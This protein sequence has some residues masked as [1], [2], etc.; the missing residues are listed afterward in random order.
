M[1]PDDEVENDSA[2]AALSLI[3]N[4]WAEQP[5]STG[6]YRATMGRGR[7][8]VTWSVTHWRGRSYVTNLKIQVTDTSSAYGVTTEFLRRMSVADLIDRGAVLLAAASNRGQDFHRRRY[9]RVTEEDLL[10]I[11]HTFAGAVATGQSGPMAVRNAFGVTGKTAERLI[12]QARSA[13]PQVMPS[14]TRGPRRRR[15]AGQSAGT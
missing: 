9:Q 5:Y 10:R 13:H 11:A 15:A 1:R 14:P 4:Q 3:I 6:T 12:A 8:L 2:D 7:L